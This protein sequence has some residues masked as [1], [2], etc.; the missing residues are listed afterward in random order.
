MAFCLSPEDVRVFLLA[1]EILRLLIS[2]AGCALIH[3][4]G[5]AEAW[6]VDIL[7]WGFTDR[8]G[9]VKD[10]SPFAKREHLRA[11]IEQYI[12]RQRKVILV[13]AS[14]GGSV[15]IDIVSTRSTCTIPFNFNPCAGRSPGVGACWI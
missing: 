14:L 1:Q 3:A 12:G 9:G 4:A 13:G 7:G 15:A 10:Y 2:R 8:E 11:F 6:A 5:G